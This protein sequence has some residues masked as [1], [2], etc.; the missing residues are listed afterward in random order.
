MLVYVGVRVS[1]FSVLNHMWVYV[2]VCGCMRGVVQCGE[3][4]AGV[5]WCMLVYVGVC[6]FMR[7]EVQCDEPYTGVC[8]CMCV[9]VY[10]W[11]GSVW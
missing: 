3:P 7:G 9:C 2:G 5:C 1:W 6:G 10:A 8:G 11:C 4:H